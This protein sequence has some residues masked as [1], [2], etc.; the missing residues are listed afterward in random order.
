MAPPTSA[1]Y[2]FTKSYGFFD[3]PYECSIRD[4]K[5]NNYSTN[6]QRTNG[7]T[8]IPTSRI[9]KLLDDEFIENWVN[10]F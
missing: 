5:P 4:S 1:S 3:C 8:V 7:Y 6:V 9:L 2:S 10:L